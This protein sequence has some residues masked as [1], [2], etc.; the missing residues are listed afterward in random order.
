MG[1]ATFNKERLNAMGAIS[2]D[3]F[4]SWLLH[5]LMTRVAATE[6]IQALLNPE[7]LD[8]TDAARLSET[9]RCTALTPTCEE[10]ALLAQQSSALLQSTGSYVRLSISD[11]MSRLELSD[12]SHFNTLSIEM[13]S[14]MQMAVMWLA[15]Q[16][17]GSIMGAVLQGA[18]DHFCP[19][20]NPYRMLASSLTSLPASARGS[21]DLFDGFCRLRSLPMPIACAAHGVVLGGGL[22][23]CLLTDFVA[24]N[25]ASTIQVGERSRGIH[26]AGL[27]T[28]TLADAVGQDVA[29]DMYL[30]ERMALA[31]TA[32]EIGLVQS[33]ATSVRNARKLAY[34]LVRR[35]ASSADSHA[36]SMFAELWLL[37]GE[38][39]PSDRRVLALDA[40]A[41]AQS[42]PDVDVVFTSSGDVLTRRGLCNMVHT[43]FKVGVEVCNEDCLPAMWRE[44][45]YTRVERG[46]PNLS[47]EDAL[48][49][50]LRRLT[51]AQSG[52]SEIAVATMDSAADAEA[53]VEEYRVELT[54]LA[55]QFTAAITAEPDADVLAT[56]M[57]AYVS[58]IRDLPSE[59]KVDR[60]HPTVVDGTCRCLLML[61][62]GMGVINSQPPLVIAHSLLGDHRGYGRLLYGQSVECTREQKTAIQHCDIFAMRDRGLMGAVVFT[63][64]DAGAMS[65]ANVY[66]LALAAAFQS[67]PFDLMGASFGA[68]LASH[69]S[70][71][72]ACMGAWPRRLVRRCIMGLA[73]AWGW[74]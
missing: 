13:A 21:I 27:L 24:C 47:C 49:Q 26:P 50:V 7:L 53:S 71:A 62:R 54:Q 5:G 14:D 43:F 60:P 8:F 3:E 6:R 11:N 67:G 18:G 46:Q 31:T 72:A 9:Q 35:F 15:A 61:R 39:P 1:A 34:D 52:Q 22:A 41:Q 73:I 70:C 68:V 55:A 42:S 59:H 58:P 56:L 64:D 4:V 51:R 25:D 12:P 63:L 28:R 38:S 74:P 2:L 57:Q 40:F 45:V 32:C 36:Q 23:I 65:M 19:G 37:D 29:M 17:R 33:V 30:S 69:V 10:E 16:E 66:G 44:V 20:G 48:T